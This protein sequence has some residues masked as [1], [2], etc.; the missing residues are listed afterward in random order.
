MNKNILKVAL[1]G[2]VLS[3]SLNADIT[4]GTDSSGNP[5]FFANNDTYVC[6]SNIISILTYQYL[7]NRTYKLY[8]IDEHYSPLVTLPTY[9][10]L[11]NRNMGDRDMAVQIKVGANLLPYPQIFYNNSIH[12]LSSGETICLYNGSNHA[13][14]CAMN[15][16]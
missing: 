4:L 14:S 10:E 5:A 6:S 8:I 12:N 3:T 15:D 7:V 2:L 1:T 13:W 16:Y 9:Q 11:K